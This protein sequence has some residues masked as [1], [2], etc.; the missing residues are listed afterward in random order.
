VLF[1][2]DEE[3]EEKV[4][5]YADAALTV[6]LPN[7]ITADSSGLLPPVYLQSVEYYAN[8][9]LF[10]EM[11]AEFVFVAG[12][13]SGNTGYTNAGVGTLVENTSGYTITSFL[14]NFGYGDLSVASA[15]LRTAV[16]A[17]PSAFT[18]RLV[19]PAID[20]TFSGTD[21]N[22]STPGVML[23]LSIGSPVVGETYRFW[24]QL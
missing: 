12:L 10:N 2:S 21:A 15:D 24:R 13:G 22:L 17:D 18:F 20:A 3:M 9:G 11:S 5:I 6:P 14:A 19:G 1:T 7:P 8:G 23:W 4:E 16:Q